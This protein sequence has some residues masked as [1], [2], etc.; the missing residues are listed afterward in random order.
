MEPPDTP[1]P[2]SSDQTKSWRIGC[3]AEGFRDPAAVGTDEETVRAFNKAFAT[4]D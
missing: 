4:H 3:V 1:P 2:S